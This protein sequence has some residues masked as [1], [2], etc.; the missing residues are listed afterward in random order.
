MEYYITIK[1]Q[2]ISVSVDVYKEFCRFRRKEKYF[3]ES[4][5]HNKVFS[6]DAL[7]AEDMNGAEIWMDSSASVE[8]IVEQQIKRRQ[9]YQAIQK[10][11]AEEK[12]LI[13]RIY[14]YEE[15]LRQIAREKKVPVTTLQYRHQKVLHKLKMSTE[16]AANV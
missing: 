9:L 4:D 5:F 14:F 6:Y 11:E 3:R 16:K 15:S 12:E 7:D 10:L 1:G 2:K 8:D 13:I